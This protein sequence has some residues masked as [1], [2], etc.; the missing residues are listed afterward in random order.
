MAISNTYMAGITYFIFIKI[1]VALD[2]S[3]STKFKRLRVQVSIPF[4]AKEIVIIRL[5][6][7]GGG[8]V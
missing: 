8:H 1:M 7:T 6:V 5:S 3:Y 2:S 4:I